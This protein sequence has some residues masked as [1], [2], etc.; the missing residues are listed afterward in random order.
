MSLVL[1]ERTAAAEAFMRRVL[2]DDAPL[3]PEYPLVFYDRFDGRVVALKE[4][5]DVRS[6]C[7]VLA[8]EFVTPN[9]NVRGGLIG[10]VVTD[11]AWRDNGLATRILIEAEATLEIDGCAFVLLWAEDPGF[12]LRR[13][14]GPIGREV[15]FVLSYDLVDILPDLDGIREMTSADFESVHDLYTRHG[16][17]VSRSID[18]TRALLECPNMTSLVYERDGEVI[19]YTCMGRGKD[20]CDAIH[21]WSGEVDDV[22]GLIRA[23]LVRRF[24]TEQPEDRLAKLA[25]PDADLR[26]LFLMAPPSAS[27]LCGR[28]EDLGAPSSQ[29]M[30]GLG[31]ILDRHATAA[32][33][34]GILGPKGSI[35]VQ[36]GEGERGFLLR[37]PKAEASVDDEGVLALLVGVVD[38]QDDVTAFLAKLGL[39]GVSLPIEPF[40]W[41]LDSI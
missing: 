37:G 6:A 9:G 32:C 1:D 11:P 3:A 29:S 41:G 13:G 30:L 39:D 35:E 38:V 34:N 8:R 7:G 31:K 20:L 21:E 19:A 33:L 4:G 17:R 18:E 24:A 12:Y 27:K 22:L 16:V 5:D 14:Y 26:Y 28:L 10:S 23:N 25:A 36:D 2:R 40:A 15:D